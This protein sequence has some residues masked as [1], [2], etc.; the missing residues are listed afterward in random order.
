MGKHN[1]KNGLP[2]TGLYRVPAGKVSVATITNKDRKAI[3]KLFL[4]GHNKG[5]IDREEDGE[6]IIWELALFKYE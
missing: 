6:R 4:A 5:F 3:T 2:T 1:Q